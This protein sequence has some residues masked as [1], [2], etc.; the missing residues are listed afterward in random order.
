MIEHLLKLEDYAHKLDYPVFEM[1]AIRMRAT[2]Y[3]KLGVYNKLESLFKQA[4]EKASKLKGDEM[5][6][7]KGSLFSDLMI[8]KSEMEL[9][10]DKS[11][12]VYLKESLK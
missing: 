8:L 5:F 1:L 4:L 12:L 11:T 10:Y 6:A 9:P 3:M 2:S 7:G